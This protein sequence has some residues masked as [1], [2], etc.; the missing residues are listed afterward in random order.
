M[1]GWMDGR[2]RR[3]KRR[4]N[5]TERERGRGTGDGRG[6]GS[7]VAGSCRP[8]DSNGQT[9]RARESAEGRSVG[10]R[11]DGRR[12][13]TE[14]AAANLDPYRPK[15]RNNETGQRRKE[16]K[17]EE[18]TDQDDHGR[19]HAHGWVGATT[20]GAEMNIEDVLMHRGLNMFIPMSYE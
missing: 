16:R 11:N 14:T 13:A 6:G 12:T 7:E 3:T 18:E 1:D 19:T 2:S 9:D 10:R 15:M 8:G 17:T 5:I 20:D 4:R